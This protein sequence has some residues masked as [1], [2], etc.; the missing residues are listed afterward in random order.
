MKNKAINAL[1]EMGM[2]ANTKGFQYIVDAMCLFEEEKWRYA[3]TTAIYCK[4]AEMHNTSFSCIE[5]AIRYA[6]GVVLEKGYLEN[7]EK[8]LTLQ[9]TTNSNLL[10][11]FYMRLT[12][13]DY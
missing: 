6:F 3:K 9:H 8:Y 11:V 10:Q 13:E 4:L 1:I 2:P 12:Q 7:V 5:R